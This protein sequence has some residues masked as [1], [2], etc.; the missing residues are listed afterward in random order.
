MRI[1][2]EQSKPA[3]LDR[4]RVIKEDISGRRSAYGSSFVS[5]VIKSL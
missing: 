2:E 5:A 3:E 1:N 4:A